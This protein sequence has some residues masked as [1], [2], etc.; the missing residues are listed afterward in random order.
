MVSR[1][2]THVPTQLFFRTAAFA[3]LASPGAPPPDPSDLN[4]D[5]WDGIKE[6]EETKAQ[7]DLQNGSLLT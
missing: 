7:D 4:S 1:T 3:H 2:N 5:H 6:K